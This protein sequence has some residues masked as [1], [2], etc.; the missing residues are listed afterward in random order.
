MLK[1]IKTSVFIM[2]SPLSEDV[3]VAN[4]KQEIDF[5]LEP[6]D[7]GGQ[8]GIK[9]TVKHAKVAVI[10]ILEIIEL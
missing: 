4:I 6:F 10:Y 2:P 3:S 5:S 1:L 9:N 7:K 8:I